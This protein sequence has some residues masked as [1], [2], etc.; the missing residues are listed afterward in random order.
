MID[1]LDEV[2]QNYKF[3]TVDVPDLKVGV[4]E[5]K[6]YF[7]TENANFIKVIYFD[8]DL[9]FY[10]SKSRALIGSMYGIVGRIFDNAIK[11]NEIIKVEI[12][13][14]RSSTGYMSLAFRTV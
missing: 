10:Q 2:Q 14:R 3:L 6:N 9:G 1:L 13:N 8:T 11:N 12:V 7:L 4:Y 5:I